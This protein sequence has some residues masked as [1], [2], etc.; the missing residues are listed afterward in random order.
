MIRSARPIGFSIAVV[1]ALA[2]VAVNGVVEDPPPARPTVAVTAA[3]WLPV[4]EVAW[5][6]GL[7][8]HDGRLLSARTRRVLD[9]HAFPAQLRV[10]GRLVEP[11][12]LVPA[13]ARVVVLPGRDRVEPLAH[14]RLPGR[15]LLSVVH[16]K[17]VARPRVVELTVGAVSGEEVRR[18]V[19]LVRPAW[20]QP[21]RG[22][23][24][25]TFD[26]GPDPVW[27]PRVLALLKQRRVHA[28]F[29][30]V[31]REVRKHPEL[32]R[33]ILADGHTLCD[34]TENHDEHLPSET[35]AV[36]RLEILRGADAVRRATGVRPVWFRAPGGEWSPAVEQLIGEA[37]MVPLKWTIDPRDWER[38]PARVIVSRVLTAA[39]PGGVLLLHDGGGDRSQTWAAL[40]S[41][42]VALPRIGLTFAEPS[43]PAPS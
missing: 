16:G 39:R 6:T 10:A 37:G 33:R 8:V 17:R 27:T 24:L 13:D 7:S 14:R 5:R 12:D 20:G 32:V 35:V 9:P 23:V 43:S 1:L 30:V 2:L 41:L 4:G 34:H 36:A 28:V 15:P 40:R 3:E 18:R 25:L 19:V 38:P 22:A 21:R 29:C 31:G 42:L 11:S 26:D